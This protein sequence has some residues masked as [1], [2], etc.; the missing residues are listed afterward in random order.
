MTSSNLSKPVSSP[1]H[2]W[3]SQFLFEDWGQT[4]L[5]HW[6]A[7][8]FVVLVI[9]AIVLGY[10]GYG[11]YKEEKIQNDQ[12]IVYNFLKT[13]KPSSAITNDDWGKLKSFFDGLS[14]PQTGLPVLVEFLKRSEGLSKDQEKDAVNFLQSIS[15]KCSKSDLCFYYAQ[16]KLA[17]VSEDMG[18]FALADSSYKSLLTS[19]WKNEEQLYLDL[20]RVAYLSGNASAVKSYSDYFLKQYPA[21]TQA[22]LVKYFAKDVGK[23]SK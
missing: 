15:Q 6:R 8:V 4:V 22:G 12:V 11:L 5:D 3:Y 2:Q 9:S 16:L 14:Y 1:K 23:S 19:P 18:N 20:T 7:V 21:S 17:A 10:G 13:W